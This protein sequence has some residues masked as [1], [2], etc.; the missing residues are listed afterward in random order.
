MVQ[1]NLKEAHD[2]Q[3]SYTNLIQAN[4]EYKVSYKV[5]L[6]ISLWKGVIEFG[7]CSTTRSTSRI[8]R[9][10]YGSID[11]Y[12]AH[13]VAKGFYQRPGVDFHDTFSPVV[14]LTTV[15]IML[16]IA[17]SRGWQL[18]QLDVNNAFL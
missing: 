10:S 13:L 18:R 15:C 1:A 16:S 7:K 14:K 12:K 8:K 5:F 9:K 4:I 6:K 2:R 17:L 11:R 3:R